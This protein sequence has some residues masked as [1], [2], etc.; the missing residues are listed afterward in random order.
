MFYNDSDSNHTIKRSQLYFIGVPTAE[1]LH[2]TKQLAFCSFSSLDLIGLHSCSHGILLSWVGLVLLLLSSSLP[3]IAI[4]V[5]TGI[6][7]VPVTNQTYSQIHPGHSEF[8]C[9]YLKCKKYFKLWNHLPPLPVSST[10]GS[11]RHSVVPQSTKWRGR[12]WGHI[13]PQGASLL[14]AR[15]RKQVDHYHNMRKNRWGQVI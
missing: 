1:E 3:S 12:R 2:D 4:L 6:H 5:W 8:L 10:P 13:L 14:G 7:Q 9:S 15:S 11:T